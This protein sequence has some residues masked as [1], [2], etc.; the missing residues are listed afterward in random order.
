MYD[1]N[2][3]LVIHTSLFGNYMELYRSSSGGYYTGEE[4]WER[5]E[6]GQWRP[7]GYTDDGLEIVETD[8]AGLVFLE[9]VDERRDRA[10]VDVSQY[11]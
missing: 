7:C 8:D 3:Q 10:V 2:R 11:R 9:P 1:F 6:G 4:L 5:L